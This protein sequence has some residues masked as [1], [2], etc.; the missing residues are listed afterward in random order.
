ML[1]IKEQVLRRKSQGFAYIEW[2]NPDA[3]R[4]EDV[5]TA[6]DLAA[7]QGLKVIAK[8]P[9]LMGGDPLRYVAH[10]AV[11]GIIVEAGAGDPMATDVLRRRANKPDLPV[12][13]VFFGDGRPKAKRTASLAASYQNMRVTYSPEGEYEDAVDVTA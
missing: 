9:G 5:L 4:V 7:S 13:F 2:D 12:W 3:Y 11:V 10:P 6:V 1:N 8:N